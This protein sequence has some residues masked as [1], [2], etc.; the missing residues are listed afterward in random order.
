MVIPPNETSFPLAVCVAATDARAAS[1]DHEFGAAAG[2]RC[3]VFDSQCIEAIDVPSPNI[4][5][6]RHDDAAP[7]L[8]AIDDHASGTMSRNGVLSFDSIGLQF[9]VGLNSMFCRAAIPE[10]VF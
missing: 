5:R 6:P 8:G 9:H 3:E 4:T 7:M 10:E 2:E 1:E